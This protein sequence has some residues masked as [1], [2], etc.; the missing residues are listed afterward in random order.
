MDAG[1]WIAIG[2]VVVSLFAAVFSV[3]QAKTAAA[4]AKEAK[5]QADAAEEQNRLTRQQLDRD[6][7]RELLASQEAAA[8]ALR[9]AEQ[10]E[11][12]FT[13]NGGVEV[14]LTN[15]GDHAIR[16][17]E[18]LDL[19]AT[20]PGPW[21]GWSVNRNIPGGPLVRTTRAVIES[22]DKMVVACWLLNEQGAPEGTLPRGVEAVAR[23]QD[24]DGQWWQT[25]TSVGPQRIE[26][27]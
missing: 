10:V 27:P 5:R 22:R 15:S 25:N 1:D 14:T 6:A 8:A 2:A 13:D 26:A 16:N 12:S 7:Q 9:Q 4:S 20:E 21:T 23:F 17:V 18:L 24:V 19:H 11:F 3:W